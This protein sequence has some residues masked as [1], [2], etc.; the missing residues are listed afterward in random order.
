MSLHII[1]ASAGTGKTERLSREVAKALSGDGNDRIDVE[2]LVAVTYTRKAEAELKARIRRTLVMQGAYEQAQR[3]PLAYVGT[4]HAICN[5][6]LTEFALAEGLSPDVDVLPETISER[7]LGEALEAAL[8]NDEHRRL[9]EIC[10]RLRPNWDNKI[11]EYRWQSDAQDLLDLARSNRIAADE[12]P[13]MAERSIAGMQPILGHR[14]KDGGKV[15]QKLVEALELALRHLGDGD[16]TGVTKN[17][18]QTLRE[19]QRTLTLSGELPWTTWAKLTTVSAAA[20]HA[21]VM[22]VVQE[23]AAL[24]REHP[25]FHDDMAGYVRLIYGAVAKGLASYSRWKG[26]RRYIDY[27]DMEERALDL[28]CRPEIAGELSTRLRLLVVDEFQDTSPIQLALFFRLEAIC[29]QSVWVGDRKQSIFAFRGADPALMEAVVAEVERRGGESDVLDTN[30]R[31]RRSLVEFT[32]EAFAR[33]FAVHGYPRKQVFV[34]AKRGEDPGLASLPPLGCWLLETTKVEDDAAALAEGIRRLLAHPEATPVVDR[35]TGEVRNLRASDVAVLAATNDETGRLAQALGARGIAAAVPR[36][37]LLETPEGTMLHAALR[38]VADI[39]DGVARA[40]LDALAEFGG[41]DPDRWLER[42]LD[43]RAA[44]RRP[45]ARGLAATLDAQREWLRQLAPTETVD[46]LVGLLDLC[47]RCARW[48]RPDE[49][50]ANIEAFRALAAEYENQCA[51]TREAGSIV[52]FLHFLDDAATSGIDGSDRERS[53][54]QHA[55]GIDAVEIC[56]YHRAKGLEWPVVILTSL[57]SKSRAFGLAPDAAPLRLARGGRS[58]IFSAVPESDAKEFDAQAPLAGRWLR[59]WPWPYGGIQNALLRDQVEQTPEA[60]RI[61]LA[62]LRESLRLLYVGFTRA[63]DHLIL[64]ARVKRK[65]RKPPKP[66]RGEKSKQPAS[67]KPEFD[68]TVQAPWLETIRDDSGSLLILPTGEDENQEVTIRGV[69]G[70]DG[71][72]AA[73]VWLLDEGTEPPL[74]IERID[75]HVWYQSAPS[76]ARLGYSIAPSR[77]ETDWTDVAIGGSSLRLVVHT[78]GQR[79]SL[80]V[81]EAQMDEIGTAIHSFF[82]ADRFEQ[83]TAHRAAIA[84]RI[85]TGRG[86]SGV[87]GASDLVTASDA[88]RGWVDTQWPGA[89]WRR[90]VPLIGK[91]DTPDG[92]R[93]ISGSI[94]LLLETER[95]RVIV[96]HKTYPGP[97]SEWEGRAREHAAQLDAYRRVLA[98]DGGSPVLA[99]LIHFPVGGGIVEVASVLST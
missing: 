71:Q 41:E 44:E 19:A 33:A 78:L 57:H 5:R 51:A 47:V 45:D 40:H 4:V 16:D 52:G 17:A 94:D 13:A 20:A 37:R 24:H 15:D 62:E 23:A 64:A 95:G 28:L 79:L 12:L 53:D 54:T 32:S 8:D 11:G 75:T 87:I 14:Q 56:T 43:A 70:P 35:I 10:H 60:T 42:L 9:E 49:R 88:L 25:L 7:A 73:R 99:C 31:S 66:K 92:D 50:L 6:L 69:T 77:A 84:S 76:R 80:T 63:R 36:K 86:L 21:D 93:F 29:R 46:E 61:A 81:G 39:E 85:L 68:V 96:D 55:G 30:Y 38:S 67:P 58:E 89:R 91:L 98:M 34:K 1:G 74:R 83:S 48:P 27:V 97:A 22:A 2:G 18:I 90:E 65:E 82:A 26:E 59:F 3:L 72:V